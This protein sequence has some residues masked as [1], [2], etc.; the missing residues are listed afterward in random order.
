M[1]DLSLERIRNLIHIVRGH[2]VVLHTDLARLYRVPT[3]R[4]L[5]HAQ[6]LPGDFCFRLE[7]SEFLTLGD[8]P[9]DERSRPYVFT[10][11]GAL[12]VAYVLNVPEAIAASSWVLRAFVESRQFRTTSEMLA[13]SAL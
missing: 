11:H 9:L 7:G 3:N 8:G 5:I 13:E 4:L 10:E 6:R 2:H 12:V 1:N